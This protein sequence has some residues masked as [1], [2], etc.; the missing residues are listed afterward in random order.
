MTY[1][2]PSTTYGT[3]NVIVSKE[4]IT[5]G[6]SSN[7]IS[8][9]VGPNA[10]GV[11]ENLPYINADAGCYK[12]HGTGYKKTLLRRR[13]K[14]CKKCAKKYGTDTTTICFETVPTYTSGVV[15]ETVVP[16]TTYSSTY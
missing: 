8:N 16:A 10:Y 7:V 11:P 14:A 15:T 2:N 1:Y 13:W 3:S 5:T 9:V 4:I 6:T 12:C